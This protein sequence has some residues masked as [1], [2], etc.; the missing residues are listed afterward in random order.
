ME[1]LRVKNI[2]GIFLFSLGTFYRC[3]KLFYDCRRE[4]EMKLTEAEWQIMNA[5]WQKH[6]ATAREIM[7]R[8]PAGVNWAYTTIKTLLTRLLEKKAV[9]E[10]KQGNTSVYD[11][12][13]SQ[14]KAR[15][16]AFRSLLD[17][18]FDGA[19]GPL[20]HFLAEEK[21]LTAQEKEELAR[22]LESEA[23]NK[24]E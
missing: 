5:L 10:I 20:V 21:Q 24:G 16:N 22:I 8:L 15:L 17:Q 11:P 2:G 23:Q 19:I 3:S 7:D 4:H 9:S 13:V 12:L 6:P 1:F 14:Q 18:A